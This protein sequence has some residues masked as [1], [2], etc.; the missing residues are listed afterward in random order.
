MKIYKV[1]CATIEET[2]EQL[3]RFVKD[4]DDEEKRGVREGLDEEKLALFDLLISGKKLTNKEREKIKEV[5]TE[6]LEGLKKEKLNMSN[7]R[8]KESTK[9]DVKTFIYNFLYDENTGL[10]IEQYTPED[11]E[12]KANI[13][14]EHVYNQ[15]NSSYKNVY[16][17]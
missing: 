16:V 4:L 15:Y 3:M 12:I 10:P 8:D 7:W 13:V 17:S 1:C 6:L 5:G 9:A 14:F 11:V 2:F